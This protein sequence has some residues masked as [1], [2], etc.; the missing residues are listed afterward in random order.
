MYVF[1]F[2]TYLILSF[3]VWINQ[4]REFDNDAA[5]QDSI[6]TPPYPTA[7]SVRRKVVYDQGRHRTRGWGGSDKKKHTILLKICTHDTILIRY[8]PKVVRH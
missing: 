2:A 6:P 1:L 7:N 4:Y 5:V 3:A 8:T